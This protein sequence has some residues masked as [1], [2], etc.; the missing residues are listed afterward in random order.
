MP[1]GR[2]AAI[3]ATSRVERL[4]EIED[5]AALAHRDA[6]ADRGLAVEAELRRRRVLVAAVTCA[7]SF[8]RTCR[9]PTRMSTFSRL[10]TESSAPLTRTAMRSFGVSTMPEAIT[11]FWRADLLDDQVRH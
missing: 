8:R 6:D 5:V 11:A 9:S 1:T 2:S 4:A 10:S 3:R 7:M